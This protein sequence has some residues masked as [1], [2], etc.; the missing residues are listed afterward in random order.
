M[1]G[2]ALRYGRSAVFALA[3][4]WVLV[5]DFGVRAASDAAPASAVLGV[6]AE[7]SADAKLRRIPPGARSGGSVSETVREAAGRLIVKFEEDVPARAESIV[8]AGADAALEERVAPLDLSLV[9]VAP[10]DAALAVA[11]LEASPK[12]EYVE[13]DAVVRGT[14]AIPND[15]LFSTQWGFRLLDLPDA[16]GLVRSGLAVPV[17]VL[18][19]GVDASHPDLQGV[20]A[21]GIDL[22]NGDADAMDDNGHGTSA[23]G[24]IAARADNG[25]GGAG[26]CRTCT[27][28]PVKVL[29]GSGAGTTS[30]VAQGI[31]WAA[32]HGARVIN[33]SLGSSV[34]TQTLQDAVAYATAKGAIVIASA[35]NAGTF[36]KL[37]PAADPGVVSVGATDM[38][39]ALYEWSNRG[40]WV[41][42]AAPGCN[43]AP[44][45]GGAYVSFCGTSSA[46][47][48]VAGLAALALSQAPAA[49]REQVERALGTGVV[50]VQDVAGGRVNARQAL[51]ALG[52][53]VPPVLRP[54]PPARRL[55]KSSLSTRM[56]VRR[57]PQRV[58]AGRVAVVLRSPSPKL[59]VALLNA[60]GRVLA[61][62]SGR[63]VLRLSRVLPAGTY[64]ATVAGPARTRFALEL[65]YVRT[66]RERPK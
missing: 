6:A 51:V 9:E 24:V 65:T 23:A 20:V 47:P 54:E 29:D 46:A 66:V 19:S 44:A 33:L 52:A 64:R 27:I 3:L 30:M 58:S 18:D 56:P 16:W 11:S 49:P 48:V 7:A 34:P 45:L 39:D 4:T 38:R 32:D 31:V 63:T 17:A 43:T 36:D 25:V 5:G 12:V 57:Y 1:S 62:A 59:R 8:L 53:T 10:A 37:Y 50:R 35:G 40:A 13:R 14:G 22:V 55:V 26:V 42:L 60:R 21:G 61:R 2:K 15:V 41:R 28:L